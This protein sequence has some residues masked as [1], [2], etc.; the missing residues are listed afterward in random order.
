MNRDQALKILSDHRDELS[1]D[2][3]LRS[4][5]LFG[6]VARAEAKEASDVDVLVEFGRPVTL[7]DLAGLQQRLQELLGV[8]KV[9]VVMRDSI[10][11]ALREDILKEAIRVG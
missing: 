3:G 7:F 9:D 10:F 4:L 5:A 8:A 2:Y 1:R 6:S 11:P